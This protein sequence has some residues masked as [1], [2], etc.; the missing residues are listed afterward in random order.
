MKKPQ[1]CWDETSVKLLPPKK[2]LP[3]VIEKLPNLLLYMGA[4]EQ[5]AH[6]YTG[7]TFYTD[8]IELNAALVKGTEG[9]YPLI[10]TDAIIAA[11]LLILGHLYMNRE[12]VIVGVT[13]SELPMNSRYLLAPYRV[14]MGA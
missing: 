13:S 2:G 6:D 12:D 9:S 11:M 5:A 7:R 8:E 14:G 3:R 10:V 4:A 1:Y